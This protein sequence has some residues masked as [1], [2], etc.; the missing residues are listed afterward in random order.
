MLRKCLSIKLA[1]ADYKS[2]SFDFKAIDYLFQLF[3]S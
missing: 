3:L 2:Q 1:K